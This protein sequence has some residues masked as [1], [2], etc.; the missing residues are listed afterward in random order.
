MSQDHAHGHAHGPNTLRALG[1]VLGFNTFFLLVEA[2][3]G[4]WSGSLALLSDAAHMLSDVAGLLLAF[5]AARISLRRGALAQTFGLK[6]VEVLGAFVNGLMLL[7]GSG[8]IVLEAVRRLLGESPEIP[9][10]PV[11]VV[12]VIGLIVN[13]GSAWVLHRASD[14]SLNMRGA[15]LHMLADALGSVGAVV[16]A[17]FLIYGV[18]IADIL[19]SLGIAAMVLWATWHLLEDSGRI[20]LEFAPRGTDLEAIQADLRGLPCVLDLHDFHVWTLDGRLP[21]LS[22]H[23]VVEPGANAHE[24]R[25]AALDVLE[26]DHEIWHATIQVELGDPDHATP[27]WQ[28]HA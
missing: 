18:G 7:L 11:L 12:A 25:M 9:G 27:R 1:L 6:R 10:W 28:D 4:W 24:L 26:R 5:L 8:W 15:L 20:L 16:A 3:V 22:V 23:L 2:G 13:L 21:L 14:E 17:I 19:V